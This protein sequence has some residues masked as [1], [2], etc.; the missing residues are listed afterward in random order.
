MGRPRRGRLRALPGGGGRGAGAA[1]RPT[2][3]EAALRL[4]APAGPLARLRA[5]PPTVPARADQTSPLAPSPRT[6]A[7]SRRLPECRCAAASS[8]YKAASRA[9][10]R[11]SAR[12]CGR[13][14]RAGPGAGGGLRLGSWQASVADSGRGA[15]R[16]G[17]LP[18][19]RPERRPL[20][21]RETRP[22]GVRRFLRARKCSEAAR[23]GEPW[24]RVCGNLPAWLFSL[25]APFYRLEAPPVSCD[26][27][28]VQS[29]TDFYC[30]TPAR[31]QLRIRT[32]RSDSVVFTYA[33]QSNR[34]TVTSDGDR[35]W[36]ARGERAA[37]L[38]VVP[39]VL[40]NTSNFHAQ[41]ALKMLANTRLEPCVVC[42]VTSP[43]SHS[44][45]NSICERGARLDVGL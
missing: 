4:G 15:A 16:G 28:G 35:G 9:S 29:L 8:G 32:R 23:R 25:S 6:W 3:P 24:A 27:N 45:G 30:H 31:A 44:V 20:Q 43:G 11:R 10:A 13:R 7:Q 12:S 38:H 19:Q 2:V 36:G 26:L 1:A 5:P 37:Q 34:R 18:P 21:A 39:H 40:R 22:R 42:A 17:C 41:A 14:P 33:T